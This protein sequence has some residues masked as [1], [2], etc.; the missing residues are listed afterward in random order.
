MSLPGCGFGNS[1][2]V[3]AMPLGSVPASPGRGGGLRANFRKFSLKVALVAA[4]P[5]H[6]CHQAWNQIVPA[7]KLHIRLRP[8]LPFADLF[9]P[10][11]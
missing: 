9:F 6:R 10:A 2:L 3:G 4:K 8:A 11:D 1:S 7:P 5:R